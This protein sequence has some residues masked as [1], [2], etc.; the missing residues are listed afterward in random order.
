MR[1]PKSVPVSPSG[2][3]PASDLGTAVSS[4]PSSPPASA[5]GSAFISPTAAGP[6]T[7]IATVPAGPHKLVWKFLKPLSK[8]FS[9][10]ERMAYGW[11]TWLA[12]QYS[13]RDDPQ[14]FV[15]WV[16][17]APGA[18][19]HSISHSD[20]TKD[21]IG[22]MW[23]AFVCLCNSSGLSVEE[24]LMAELLEDLNGM[25]DFDTRHSSGDEGS[26]DD[27]SSSDEGSGDEGSG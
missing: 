22:D 16:C 20:Y 1:T 3:P 2:T 11:L 15:D 8:P 7:A 19:W 17:G 24:Q 14:A 5:S 4:S 25:S 21:H 13:G 23:E 26:S 10:K 9:S 6:A 27:G 18:V 12:E